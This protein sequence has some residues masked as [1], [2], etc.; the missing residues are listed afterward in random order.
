MQVEILKLLNEDN[1]IFAV[2]DEDQ[3]I[4]GFRGS[5]PECMVK[6]S[7]HFEGGG[8]LPLST[9]YRCPKNIVEISM[10]IIK[11]NSM[12]NEKNIIAFKEQDGGIAVLNNVN[13]NSQAEEISS[14]IQNRNETTG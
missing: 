3:C 12:R 10:N 5:N 13:E 2:G 1:S 14:I 7:E 4:Y 11:N 6:F 8:K 9:N